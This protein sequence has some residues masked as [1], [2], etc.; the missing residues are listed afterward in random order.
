MRAKPFNQVAC[1]LDI[2][3]AFFYRIQHLAG[4]KH[5]HTDGMS[6]RPEENCKQYLHL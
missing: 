1:G 5:G 2:F 3:A 4:K 6:R